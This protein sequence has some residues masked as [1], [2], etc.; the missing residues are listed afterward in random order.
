MRNG[1]AYWANL[2]LLL[3]NLIRCQVEHKLKACNTVSRN[4][5]K[6]EQNLDQLLESTGTITYS[7]RVD[8]SVMQN[9]HSAYS[10]VNY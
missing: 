10:N 5:K 1:K 4:I 7:L 9:L 2:G 6:H 8:Y 3:H